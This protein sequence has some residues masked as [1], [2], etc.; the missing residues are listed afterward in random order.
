MSHIRLKLDLHETCLVR[1]VCEVV[2]L[3]K[4][5]IVLVNVQKNKFLTTSKL[6]FAKSDLNEP[7]NKV[8]AEVFS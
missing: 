7:K 4:Y 1:F 8:M 2:A 3:K 5:C 6:K